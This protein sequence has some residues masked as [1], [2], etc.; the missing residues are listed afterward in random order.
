VGLKVFRVGKEKGKVLVR[1]PYVSVIENGGGKEV[2][3]FYPFGMQ[4]RGGGGK[5][6]DFSPSL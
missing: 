3:E 4:E 2:V 6:M 5:K 1:F